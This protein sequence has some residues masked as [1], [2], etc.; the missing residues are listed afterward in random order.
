MGK[1]SEFYFSSSSQKSSRVWEKRLPSGSGADC[2]ALACLEAGE[3]S[4][5]VN[6]NEE[7]SLLDGGLLGGSGGEVSVDAG[8]AAAI[9]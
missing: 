4:P 3:R 2:S 6:S 8:S 1:G 7:E 5:E 9:L